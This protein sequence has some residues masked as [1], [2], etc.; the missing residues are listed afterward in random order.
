MQQQG[1]AGAVFREEELGAAAH[2]RHAAAEEDLREDA[3]TA[4]AAEGVDKRG[5]QEDENG[6]SLADRGRRNVPERDSILQGAALGARQK[7]EQGAGREA[8]AAGGGLQA[9]AG[10]AV[11]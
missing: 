10:A 4:G 11:C 7:R 8:G 3:E 9:E 2:L 6:Q 5:V 1:D